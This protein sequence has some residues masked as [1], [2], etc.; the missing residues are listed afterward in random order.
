MAQIGADADRAKVFKAHGAPLGLCD[1][2]INALKLQA[3]QQKDGDSPIQSIVTGLLGRSGAMDGL[4]SVIEA[5]N[6]SAVD[7]EPQLSETLPEAVIREGTDELT[8]RAEE[9]S[10]QRAFMN[11]KYIELDRWGPPEVDA[12]AAGAKKPSE[13][14]YSYSCRT[15]WAMKAAWDRGEEF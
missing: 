15:L 3:N 9:V 10:T 12:E 4:R 6:H 1:K 13:S 8:L 11:T 2:L 14:Q 7:V 5:D